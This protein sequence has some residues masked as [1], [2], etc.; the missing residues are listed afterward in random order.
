MAVT[1]L[2]ATPRFAVRRSGNIYLLLIA[3]SI[4]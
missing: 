2:N 4:L 3:I 1:A